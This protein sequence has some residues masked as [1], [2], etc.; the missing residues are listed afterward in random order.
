MSKI[1]QQAE[2]LLSLQ[3][4]NQQLLKLKEINKLLKRTQT[5]ALTTESPEEAFNALYQVFTSEL[6]PDGF[7]VFH[8]SVKE[9]A[10]KI[11]SSSLALD[12]TTFSFTQ[13]N[14]HDGKDTAS[15]NW[16]SL[17]TVFYDL[18]LSPKWPNE[19]KQRLNAYQS[20]L[21]YPVDLYNQHYA[22]VLLRT[23][24]SPF[25]RED[26]DVLVSYGNFI[27][28]TFSLIEKQKLQR[29]HDLL[30]AQQ[31]RIEQS[32][33]RQEKL[34]AIGQL[35][36]GVA[37]ELNNP[38]GF[39]YSNLNSLLSY[40]ESYH[41]FMDKAIAESPSLQEIADQ[42]DLVYLKTDTSDLIEESLEGARRSREIIANL[43]EFSHP[44]DKS[45]K[46]INLVEL[47]S[48]TVHIS[49]TQVK[50]GANINVCSPET[51]ILVDGNVTQ[52]TQVLLNLL[53]NAIQAVTDGR[54]S[55]I[56]SLTKIE[57]WATLTVRDNGEGISDEDIAHIF[58]PFFTTKDVGAGTGLGLSISRAIIEQHNGSLTLDWTGNSGSC[59]VVSLPFSSKRSLVE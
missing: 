46:S 35:A 55:I 22:F 33:M 50:H 19:I 42:L 6:A 18:H 54:G 21:L 2:K 31:K 49:N 40:I 23:K 11:I 20:A 5:Q 28:T 52:L 7:L 4:Q 38:L 29:E 39:I 10:I 34:A 36:A 47:V 24:K 45:I 3:M 37:H 48:D 14:G 13:F 57:R 26:M 9:Q 56:V 27:N 58:D 44:D 32:M 59:F 15:D 8:L 25:S 30:L 17:S 12:L 51:E 41:T 43:R 1:E 16:L 53:N